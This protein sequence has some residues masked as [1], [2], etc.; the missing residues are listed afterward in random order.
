[1]APRKPPPK[2]TEEE[3]DAL[4]DRVIRMYLDGAKTAEITRETSVPRATIYWILQRAGIDPNRQNIDKPTY[5]DL[6]LT[7]ERLEGELSA[8]R[9]ELTVLNR[10]LSL[11]VHTAELLHRLKVPT[12]NGVRTWRVA[13]PVVD[14]STT[15]MRPRSRQPGAP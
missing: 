13:F 15:P 9:H 6:E 1:M 7:V 14:G 2:P 4:R 11:L 10:Q 8:A 5:E 3:R 12:P